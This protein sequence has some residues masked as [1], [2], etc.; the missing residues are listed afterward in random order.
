[1][2]AVGADRTG[3]RLSPCQSFL[4]AFDSTPYATH[5]LLV[6]RLNPLGLAY[7]HM[8]EP[9]EQGTDD[10]VEGSKDSLAPFRTVS[11]A[12]F[13]AAGGCATPLAPLPAQLLQTAALRT[14]WTLGG[15]PCSSRGHHRQHSCAPPATRS[16]CGRSLLLQ[17][18]RTSSAPAHRLTRA[19]AATRSPAPNSLIHSLQTSSSHRSHTLLTRIRM[20]ADLPATV[21]YGPC[22]RPTHQRAPPLTAIT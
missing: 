18:F 10:L 16:P 11:K 19:L 14:R 9:R 1:V 5:T 15:L 4:D 8:V 21:A 13:I 7:I 12:P 2:E 22:Y 17:S 6:E 3:I 20:P